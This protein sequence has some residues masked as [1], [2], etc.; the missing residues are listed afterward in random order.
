MNTWVIAG[1][2][3]ALILL[4]LGVIW[5]FRNG[6][7]DGGEAIGLVFIGIMEILGGIVS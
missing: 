4:T 7:G 1:I 2:V 6:L 5:I 3:T